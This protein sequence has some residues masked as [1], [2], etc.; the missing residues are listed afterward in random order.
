MDSYNRDNSA[1]AVATAAT[2]RPR[3][4]DSLFL[5]AKLSFVGTDDVLRRLSLLPVAAVVR[6]LDGTPIDDSAPAVDRSATRTGR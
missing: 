3:N 5:T 6:P 2:Q 4:R 1:D